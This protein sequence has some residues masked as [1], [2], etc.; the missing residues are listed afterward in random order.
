M[1]NL[2]LFAFDFKHIPKS[3][4]KALSIYSSPRERSDVRHRLSSPSFLHVLREKEKDYIRTT[5]SLTHELS[6]KLPYHI[7]FKIIRVLLIKWLVSRIATIFVLLICERKLLTTS[8]YETSNP[9]F[10]KEFVKKIEQIQIIIF[11]ESRYLPQL[12][13]DILSI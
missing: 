10:F 9:I 12:C 4:K 6:L 5:T 3:S 1:L 8:Y 7:L 2:D 11:K 13:Y